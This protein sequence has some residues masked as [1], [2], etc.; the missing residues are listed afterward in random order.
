MCGGCLRELVATCTCAV[1]AQTR[2]EIA[3]LFDQGKSEDEILQYYVAKHGSFQPLAAPP[4]QGFNRLAW[5]FPYLIGAGGAVIVAVAAVRWS[6]RPERAPG[7]PLAAGDP[8][9]EERLDDELR[10]LD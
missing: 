7:A 8:V 4:D 1:A 10:N 9:L 3:S 6:R 2:K 5:L